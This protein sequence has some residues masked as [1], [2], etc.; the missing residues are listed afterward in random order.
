MVWFNVFVFGVAEMF[1]GKAIAGYEG[2]ACCFNEFV[3]DEKIFRTE[4]R[5]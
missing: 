2:I 3:V 5:I 4:M 1:A